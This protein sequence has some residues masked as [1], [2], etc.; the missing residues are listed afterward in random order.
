VKK[1]RQALETRLVHFATWLLPRLSRRAILLLSNAVGA[2]ACWLDFRGRATAHENLRKAFAKEGITP[3][4]ISRITLGSYQTFARTFFD[5][6]WSL[7]LT[8]E[9]YTDYIK[10]CFANPASEAV[11]RE[12]GCV[13]VTPHF[14][15]FELV[16]LAM[17]FRG[18]A[19]TVVA[20]D[21]K[22]PALTAIFKRLRE[23][24]GHTIIPQ[25]GAMLRLVKELKRKGHAALLTD[26]TIR[27]NK[28]AAAIDCFGL[29]TCV[30]TLHASLSRR[31]E[32]PIIAGVCIPMPDGTY[33]VDVEPHFEPA[34]FTSNAALTQAV[35][36]RFELQIR[37]H[38]EA[39]MWMY[40]HWRFLPGIE[41]DPQYPSYAN[42]NK[43]FR[44]LLAGVE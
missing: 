34:E 3:G 10:V 4:Q 27:P 15:N 44:E 26:L 9:N 25:E 42:P 23:G 24:S 36:D 13:W 12:R 21:F 7:R 35:W 30:T 6:F 17:G 32:L 31:L 14:G 11:A 29:K 41:Q 37:K 40:K 19:W 20:Q 5:L 38:P 22:N 33:V 43:P 2:A 8:K 28:T 16:S 39:W 18:F 1:I